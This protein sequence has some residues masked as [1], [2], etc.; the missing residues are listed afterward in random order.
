MAGTRNGSAPA[1]DK[2]GGNT[3]RCICCGE[4]I[5]EGRQVC[6]MCDPEPRGYQWTPP[7]KRWR[8]KIREAIRILFH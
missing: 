3:D 2:T 5:P 6:P 8:D 7:K 4:I 1:R